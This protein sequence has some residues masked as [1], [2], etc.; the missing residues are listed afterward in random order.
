MTRKR[1][2]LVD[3]LFPGSVLQ[4]LTY[5]CPPGSQPEDVIGRRV[6]AM[7][8]TRRA[9]GVVVG[10]TASAPR[11]KT[12]QPILDVLDEEEI[13]TDELRALASWIQERYCCTPTQAIRCVLP[14]VLTV[15]REE[16]VVLQTAC[17][18]EVAMLLGEQHPLDAELLRYLE[19]RKRAL[20]RNLPGREDR[21]EQDR[22]L[23]RLR[24]EGHVSVEFTERVRVPQP[25]VQHWVSLERPEALGATAARLVPFLRSRGGSCSAETLT[26]EYGLSRP[27]L[28]RL[29]TA[30]ALTLHRAPHDDAEQL[31]ELPAGLNHAREALEASQTHGSCSVLRSGGVPLHGLWGHLA[32]G[33]LSTGRG[34]LVLAPEVAD[35]RDTADRLGRWFPGQVALLHGGMTA[36]QRE[37]ACEGIRAGRTPLV[38][39]TRTAVFAPVRSVGLAILDQEPDPAYKSEETPRY[40]ARQVL[41]ERARTWK[42]TVILSSA[43]PSLESYHNVLERRWQLV[44]VSG[45]PAPTADLIDMTD[46]SQR[47]SSWHLSA[48]LAADLQRV[49]DQGLCAVLLHNRRGYA[50]FLVCKDCG[51]VPRCERCEVPLVFHRRERK[52]R[53]HHCGLVVSAPD[54]CAGCNGINLVPR[55]TGTERVEADVHRLVP[56]ASIV[57]LEAGRPVPDVE[58][59]HVVVATQAL[60]RRAPWDR[61]AVVSLLE[62]E[63]SLGFPDFRAGEHTFQIITALRQWVAACGCAPRV[64]VQ[65]RSPSTP[66]IALA[67]EGRYHDYAVEELAA[68]RTVGY[69]PYR[70]LVRIETNS[71]RES[72]ALRVARNAARKLSQ[73]AEVL[74]PSPAPISRLRGR[75]RYQLLARS[76][77][78]NDLAHLVCEAVGRLKVPRGVRLIVDPDPVSM[79]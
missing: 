15:T 6:L 21:A 59:A 46:P 67:C 76:D 79:M 1:P 33:V 7:L 71:P 40:H 48:T 31:P 44:E 12:P 74:G 37:A 3:V 78:Q 30:G 42:A 50:S 28:R 5:A 16:A 38:V 73:F 52:M 58:H 77:P 13:V 43:T 68:R 32:S 2:A 51:L 64:L 39:G 41:L 75:F 35:A 25:R 22:A 23:D 60:L 49:V 70:T 19:P 8:R 45:A 24:R 36:G 69:P 34:V 57:C 10:K 4:P 53:C 66:C 65:S 26:E 62:A 29:V 54:T 72:E 11:R 27:A 55:G 9:V 47:T 18:L 63:L 20:R 56:N 14:A 17:P 61:I